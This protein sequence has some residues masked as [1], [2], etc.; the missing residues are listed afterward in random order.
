MPKIF[1][2]AAGHSGYWMESFTYKWYYD[3][4]ALIPRSR[5]CKRAEDFASS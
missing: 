4:E 3:D 2:A 1:M 5:E